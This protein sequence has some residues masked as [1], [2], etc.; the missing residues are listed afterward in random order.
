MIA[1]YKKGTDKTVEISFTTR[2][3][4][5]IIVENQGWVDEKAGHIDFLMTDITE[6]KQA[7]NALREA[8]DNLEQRVEERTSELNQQIQQRIE[9]DGALRYSEMRF[10]DFAEGA[11]DWF[12][13]M[14]ENLRFSYFSDRFPEISGVAKEDLIGKTRQESGLDM[15]DEGVRRNIED[16]EAR[17]PFKNFEHSRVRP[18]GSVA[19]MSTAGRPVFDE[20][21]AFKGYRGTGSD[22]TELK[23]AQEQMQVAKEEAETANRTKS[24]F[25]ANMSHE[26]RTPLNAII[27][28]SSLMKEKVFGPLGNEKYEEYAGDVHDSGTHLLELINDI[29]DLSMI[30]SGELELREERVDMADVIGASVRLVESRAEKGNVRLAITISDSLPCLFADERR[31]KQVLLNLLSNAVKFTPEGG[32]VSLD[33]HAEA[34]G[35][36][37]LT[38]AD[39]GIGMAA[40]EIAKAMELFGQIDSSISREFDGTGLGLPLTKSLMEAHGGSI[41]IKSQ[42]RMGTTVTVRF[43]PERTVPS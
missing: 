36:L 14:D 31:V 17:R 11:S 1:H 20:D 19:H 35:P 7:E 2:D 3:G 40:D 41:E 37:V 21:G 43:P 27:G 38:I 23:E 24:E 42:P 6:R 29:L 13:E 5:V 33:A 9:A 15:E 30:E 12:W 32:E 39:T 28:F 8:H 4:S 22:I 26:L 10:K 25:L 34:D 18:D 16:L